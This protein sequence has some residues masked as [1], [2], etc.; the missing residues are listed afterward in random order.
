VR[1]DFVGL[2]L[3]WVGLHDPVELE[4]EIADD[5]V[6]IGGERVR[7]GQHELAPLLGEQHTDPLA[8]FQNALHEHRIARTNAQAT[9]HQVRVE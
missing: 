1:D 6:E 8:G 5:L 2:G 7:R 3:A 4:R 9:R